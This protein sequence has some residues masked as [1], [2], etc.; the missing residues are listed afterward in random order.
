AEFFDGL[1]DFENQQTQTLDSQLARIG[2]Q[3]LDIEN[4]ILRLRGGETPNDGIFGTSIGRS[5]TLE[6]TA[7]MDSQDVARAAGEAR[8]LDV[9]RNRRTVRTMDSSANRTWTH[10]GIGGGRASIP[11]RNAYRDQIKAA[12][13]RI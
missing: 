1:R 11:D 7:V 6:A 4:Q 3:R 10:E 8:T 13:D 2:K 5:T 12:Q 9:L